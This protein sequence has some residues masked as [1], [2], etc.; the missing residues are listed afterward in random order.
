MELFLRRGFDA[1]TLDEIAEAADVSKRS[2]FHYFASKEEMV[3]SAKADIGPLIAEAV[4]ARP[5][6]EP[7]LTMAEQALTEMARHFQTVEAKALARLIHDTPALAA[8]D[9]AK[10]DALERLLGESLARR[11]GRP[12]DD[13]EARVVAAAAVAILRLATEAWLASDGPEGPEVW[14]RRAFTLL[15]RAAAADPDPRSR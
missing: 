11:A 10:H 7:L 15:R 13:A 6:D 3:L 9:A 5:A 4:A 8:W 2:L 12:A 1:T 14:G